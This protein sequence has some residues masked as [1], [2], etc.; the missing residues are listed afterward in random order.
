MA[1]KLKQK[2]SNHS[3]LKK[4]FI[5]DFINSSIWLRKTKPEY[6]QQ[7]LEFYQAQNDKYFLTEDTPIPIKIKTNS[8]ETI[9]ARIVHYN[10]PL[11]VKQISLTGLVFWSGGDVA[12]KQKRTG[13]TA[14]DGGDSGGKI[15]S[16]LIKLH[17]PQ[18][19][20][21]QQYDLEIQLTVSVLTSRNNIISYGQA[22][23]RG[24]WGG[25]PNH[26]GVSHLSIILS[27]N[28]GTGIFIDI[29]GN[30]EALPPKI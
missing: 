18:Q 8:K 7:V 21:N 13:G 29:E 6:Y 10:D 4:A 27:P 19:Y 24:W 16:E 12:G 5:E 11:P 2:K 28:F 9:T 14:Q 15:P 1:P 20:S 23:V 25:N 30:F 17:S 22:H 3:S 26:S